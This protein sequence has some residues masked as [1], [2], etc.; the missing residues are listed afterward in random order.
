[1]RESFNWSQLDRNNLYSM[2]YSAGRDIVGR[3]IPV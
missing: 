3:K 1:M 2:L